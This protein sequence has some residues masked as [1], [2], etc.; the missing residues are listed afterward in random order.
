MQQ[1]REQRRRQLDERKKELMRHQ[2]SLTGLQIAQLRDQYER[3]L[4]DLE[5]AIRREEAQQLAR[6]QSQEPSA[7]P[8]PPVAQ[9]AAA[10][11]A[12]RARA[13][14]PARRW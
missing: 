7:K 2:D 4:G 8:K 12:R 5:A 10:A 1:L 11:P 14:P 13:K 9:P 3:E 6:R